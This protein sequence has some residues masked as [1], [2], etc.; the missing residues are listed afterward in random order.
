[1]KISLRK[2]IACFALLIAGVSMATA[3]VDTPPV[4]GAEVRLPDSYSLFFPS[5]KE[6]VG[7]TPELIRKPVFRNPARKISENSNIFG[8]LYYYQGTSLKQG[9][10]RINS[11]PAA[12]F[13]W[14]D[15]YTENWS[16]PMNA[17]WIRNGKLCGLSSMM[18]MGGILAYGQLEIDMASGEVE[19]FIP[20]E[21]RSDNTD[22]IYI[23]AAYREL[24]DKVYGYGYV[25]EGDAYGFK[26]AD[27]SNIDTSAPVC[28]VPFSEICTALCYNVQ[29]DAFYGVNTGGKF[30]SITPQGVQTE[31][32]ALSIP[33]LSSSVTGL[34]YSPTD[35]AY[36][37]NAY[38]QDGSSVM[39]SIDPKE[40]T[41]TKLYNNTSGEEYIYMVCTNDNVDSAA[42]ARPVYKSANFVGAS[43]S[44]SLSYTMP[45][46]TASG[47]PVS[48]NLDW[49]LYVDGVIT[50][51]GSAQAGSTV[52][53]EVTDLTGG[54]RS[55]A[56]AAGKDGK[57][58]LPVTGALW[59]GYDYP[60]PPSNVELTETTVSWD[61]S[62]GSVHDGY[63]DPSAL[64]YIVTIN[65][66]KVGETTGLSCQITLPQGK[67]YTSYSAEVVAISNGKHSE[68]GVSNYITYGE[69]LTVTSGNPLHFR[70]E[71][72][73]FPL[74]KAIDIDGKTDSYGNPRNWHF[75]ETMGFPS[76]A[77]GA[78]GEDMLIFPPV[79]FDNTTNAYCFM[80]EAGL[81][82]DID[83]TGTIEVLIGKEPTVESMT[84]TVM[85]A[86]RLYHMRG[87]ILTDFFSVP[88]PG[89][90]YLAVL[91]HTNNVAFHISDMDISLTERSADVPKIIS[92]LKATAAPDGALKAN[93]S[94]T[95]PV[96]TVNGKLIPESETLTATI[97]SR[98]YVL[99]HPYDGELYYTTTVTGKPGEVI[100]AEIATKQNYNTIGVSCS[101]DNR[102]GVET[103]TYVYTGLV[104]PYIVQNLKAEGSEDNMSVKLTWTPPVE[105]EEP[106]AIGNT[107]FYS[108]W[109]Y[110][111][112]WEFFDGAGYD[113]CEY[114]LTLDP[115]A[116]QNAYNFGIMALNDAGQSDHIASTSFII[117]TPY[118]LPMNETLMSDE[119]MYWP[120][121]IQR[122]SDEYQGTYW[123]VDDPASV[124]SLFANKS[125]I[126]YIGYI[127]D[128]KITS[129]KS[130][131][132]LPRFSTVGQSDVRFSLEYWGGPYAAPF[133]LLSDVYGNP[134]P[135]KI[136]DF[137]AGQGWITN[138]LTL[139]ATLDGLQW[140][141]LLLDADFPNN[142]T[143][144]L[145]SAYSITG[146]SSVEGVA[147]D[148]DG[149]IFS[150]PGMIHIAGMSGET[151]II[152]DPDGR[153]V[154]TEKNLGDLSGY[155]VAPGLYIVKAGTKTVKIQVR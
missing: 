138:S 39:Y 16:M 82:S 56:F 126:A 36:I 27:A 5:M 32:M 30:V 73:E 17:G 120:V 106:G 24:D 8:Y 69:P 50:E 22:N 122:P 72:Y 127:G 63:L 47:G 90:Y 2:T 11:T 80:M 108:V 29:D 98:E 94:F 92:D 45:G 66:E 95:M 25:G 18:F 101:Y 104:K 28:E 55:F 6:H 78:D 41:C 109:Y 123:M 117:G 26:S 128:N 7:S 118:T 87:V 150:S 93:I 111:N 76:F 143:F 68:P 129:A 62:V 88:E 31:I 151:L 12:T 152:S 54:M 105:G 60:N 136:G 35:N 115:G 102:S 110:S 139:P 61:A 154:R 107:F 46:Q 133:S 146:V 155:A 15:K 14:S 99:D 132:S 21:I 44:G 145:F 113:I 75:S 140:V 51:T 42:P 9:F 3:G 119:D 86:Q 116:P 13:L 148:R 100:N 112:G 142:N 71:E 74:F 89:T 141:E 53:V 38:L 124:A 33:Q 64:R 77:S 1:M 43:T 37:Y 130:C 144:A 84:R 103:T 49:K 57:W 153:I 20:L 83:D 40:K 85:P 137:P 4:K 65:D 23:T 147:A 97:V 134:T 81:I 34:V 91:T 67:P 48:G 59:I 121:M 19:D 79:N 58:S 135:Q 52:S 125:E 131:L 114:E 96:E 70:P 149:S 10:Y